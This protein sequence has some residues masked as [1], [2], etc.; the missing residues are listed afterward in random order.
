MK[1]PVRD[2]RFDFSTGKVGT[3]DV[4]VVEDVRQDILSMLALV[5]QCET[6]VIIDRQTK[7]DEKAGVEHWIA[8]GEF[9]SGEAAGMVSFSWTIKKKDP[10]FYDVNSVAFDMNSL[11]LHRVDYRSKE[12]L[13]HAF[14]R[15]FKLFLTSMQLLPRRF[16]DITWRVEKLAEMAASANKDNRETAEKLREEIFHLLG[17]LT[18]KERAHRHDKAQYR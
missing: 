3:V 13:L 1:Y 8:Y 9:S 4:D 5:T 12:D 15:E 6:E 10:S 11:G 18:T 7:T 16:P 17:E 14:E 2:E